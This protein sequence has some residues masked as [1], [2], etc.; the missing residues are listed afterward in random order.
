MSLVKIMQKESQDQELPPSKVLAV[1]A[2]RTKNKKKEYLV[3][4]ESPPHFTW[5]LNKQNFLG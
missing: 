3:N 1:V 5:E 2:T 4:W